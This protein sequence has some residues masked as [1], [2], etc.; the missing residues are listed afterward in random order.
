MISTL[1][2]KCGIKNVEEPKYKTDRCHTLDI[3]NE[4]TK[5]NI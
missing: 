3:F 4:K 5:E 2:N 1:K